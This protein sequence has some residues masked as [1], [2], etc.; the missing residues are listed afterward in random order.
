MT[1]AYRAAQVSLVFSVSMMASVPWPAAAETPGQIPQPW[2]YEGSKKLQEQERQRDQQYQQQQPSS[3]GGVAP[4]GGGG[5]G[6]AA[7]AAMDAARKKWLSQPALPPESNPLIGG[8]WTRPASTRPN[9]NDPFGQIQALAKGGMCEVLFGGGMF[10][11]R[12]D[13]M[14]GMD[15]RTPP[16][17]MDRVEYRGDAKHVVVLPKTTVKLMEFDVEGPDRINWKAANCVLVKAGS[18]PTAS[19]SAPSKGANVAPTNVA[20]A[21]SGAA[22]GSHSGSGSVLTLAVGATSSTDKVGG[23][24]LWVLKSDPNFVLIKAGVT[25]TPYGTVLQNWMRACEKRDQTC[26]TGMQALQPHSV[27]IATADAAGHAQTPP[28]PAGR[29]WVLSDARIDNQH[30]MWLQPV[31]VKGVEASVTLDKRNAMPVN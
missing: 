18:A 9:P 3:Q 27:G 25:S 15:E 8:K 13:R 26:M 29:Y 16:Q 2:T 20:N 21:P 24:K 7:G 11:F 5:A 6:G 22:T 23:R 30:L 1:R 28:L 19:S 10:E 14:I 17:E 4:G 31:D 12:P